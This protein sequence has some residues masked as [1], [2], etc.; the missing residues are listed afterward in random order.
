M[1]LSRIIQLLLLFFSACILNTQVAMAVAS[2]YQKTEVAITQ[3]Q[4]EQSQRD[5]G[6]VAKINEEN[7]T[8][9][10]KN[11]LS[12]TAVIGSL[13]TQ[14]ITDYVKSLELLVLADSR[15]TRFLSN[16]VIHF[17]TR[18]NTALKHQQSIFLNFCS[19]LVLPEYFIPALYQIDPA[20][21]KI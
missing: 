12:F 21:Q 11:D 6:V 2:V 1:M 4:A 13:T 8:C 20:F 9:E 10:D 17:Q 16:H 5:D 7:F 15:T 3:A 19:V 18:Q 14:K